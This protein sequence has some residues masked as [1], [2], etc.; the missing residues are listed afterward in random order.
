MMQDTNAPENS[1]ATEKQL[2]AKRQLQSL[3]AK[4]W[5]IGSGQCPICRGVNETWHGHPLY[6]DPG[7]IGHSSWCQL[8]A[9]I[10][11]L[12]EHPL[13]VGTYRSEIKFETYWKT[14][15]D[16]YGFEHRLLGSRRLNC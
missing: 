11:E 3:R 2:P 15:I 4:E 7:K 14:F 5:I 10:K 8:A 6:T 1:R 13:Y 12:G 16:L 9:A